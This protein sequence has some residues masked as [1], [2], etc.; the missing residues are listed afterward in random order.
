MSRFDK[1]ADRAP[2]AAFAL[3]EQYKADPS[4]TKVDLSPGFYRDKN[5]NPWVLPSV[6]LVHR[7]SPPQPLVTRHQ[8][9]APRPKTLSQTPRTTITNTY[10]SSA[11]Q[12]SSQTLA[13]SSSTLHQRKRK[14][15]LPSRPS[16][17]PAQTTSEL[18]FWRKRAGLI[19][20]GF[21]ILLGSTTTRYGRWSTLPSGAKRIH[22]SVRGLS[23]LTLRAWSRL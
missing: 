23:L 6:Q 15:S 16:Q 3:I 11:T 22:T 21:L 9:T 20:S 8:L 1:L 18:Y 13:R 5:E 10:H 14:P 4:P 17:A 7:K 19:P 12:V 2:D